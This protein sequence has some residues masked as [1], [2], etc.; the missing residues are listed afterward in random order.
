MPKR[1]HR[2]RTFAWGACI[3]ALVACLAH[4]GGWRFDQAAALA[5][6]IGEVFGGAI[7]GGLIFGLAAVARD[8]A[9]K[10]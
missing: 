9:W 2:L 1:W 6:Q 4:T 5:G 8:H 7:L 3:G 10:R